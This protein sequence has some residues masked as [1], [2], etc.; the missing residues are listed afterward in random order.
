MA[1]V[2]NGSTGISTPNMTFGD[3]DKATFGASSDLQIYHTGSQSLIDDVGTG[4]LTIRSNGT[5]IRLAD[6][7]NNRMLIA[8]IGAEVE[9]YHNGSAKL[10]TTSTGASVTGALT[11]TSF[12]G[13]GSALTG[14]AAGGFQFI[15]S[16]DLTNDV[17]AVFTGFDAAKYDSY[18]F[19]Y[20]NVIPATDSTSLDMQFSSDGGTTWATGASDYTYLRAGY[21]GDPV[22]TYSQATT[23]KIRLNTYLIGSAANEDGMSGHMDI[24]GPHLAKRT[25]TTS[26]HV[27]MGSNGG[28]AVGGLSW[29]RRNAAVVTNA[30]RFFFAA[31]NLESGT[32]TMYGM[33]NS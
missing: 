4:Q 8:K 31:G 27:G 6:S 20:S 9:L 22:W 1:I 15:S 10:A 28:L 16:I 25:M 30:V 23:T 24:H 29:G 5:D 21:A 3:N 12:A 17:Q 33:V 32:I 26:S 19:V 11:A 7:S 18:K 2:L 14:I 13:D